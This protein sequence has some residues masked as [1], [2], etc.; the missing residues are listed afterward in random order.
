ML[1]AYLVSLFV[2]GVLVLM[3]AFAGHGHDVGDHEVAHGG[4]DADVWLP[5]LSIRFWTY[6]LTAFGLTGVGMVFTAGMSAPAALPWAISGGLAVGFLVSLLA[7]LARKGETNSAAMRDDFNGKVARVIVPIRP[8]LPGKIRVQVKGDWIELL[9]LPEHGTEISADEEV[10]IVGLEN[11]R[12]RVV[13][14]SALLD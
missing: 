8:G 14:K 2:G 12:A 4:H 13:S 10:I 9:A 5:F 11:D 6:G 3:S 7:R 1:V